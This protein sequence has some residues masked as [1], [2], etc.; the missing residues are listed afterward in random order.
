MKKLFSNPFK[1]RETKY[2]RI[3][4][5]ELS[6]EIA[7]T[8]DKLLVKH[9]QTAQRASAMDFAQLKKG[10]RIKDLLGSM[11]PDFQRLVDK[12]DQVLAGA[13][14]IFQSAKDISNAK[15][16]ITDFARKIEETTNTLSTLRGKINEA[17]EKLVAKVRTWTRRILW[18][19]YFLAG[20]EL[21]ANFGVYQLLGGGALSAVAISILSALVI[22]WWAHLTPRN[23]I[24]YGGGKRNKELLVFLLFA[25]PIFVMFYLFSQMRISALIVSNPEMR[26]VFVSS[27][28]IPTLINFFGY[29]IA[30]YLVYTYRPTKAELEAYKKYRLDMEEIERLAQ[31][32]EALIA[33][34]NAE[35]PALQ[36]KLTD[37]Y[38]F[39]VLAGQLER[40]V[41]TRYEGCFEEFKSELYLR[42]NSKCDSLFSGDIKKDLPPLEL[43][44][45]T[46][47][48]TQF[49][50]CEDLY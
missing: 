7:T 23:V 43:K 11:K 13:L 26:N 22:F 9:K 40:E 45:Q 36:A 8:N 3:V 47:D 50:L 4:H 25:T 16:A 44:Y 17:S 34:R 32:R 14:S 6:Q 38:N 12:V 21:I 2:S 42:T 30:C 1:K 41:K 10:T 27:P 19:L 35:L 20:F 33:E 37:H 24:K 15:A 18:V 5:R 48:K 39:L 28:I 31:K 46:I 29:L 49:E